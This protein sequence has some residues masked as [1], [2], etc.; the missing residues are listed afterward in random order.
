MNNSQPEKIQ[1]SLHKA[2]EN[3]GTIEQCALLNYPNYINLGDHLIWLGTLF[4]LTDVLQTKINYAASTK[5]FSGVMMEKQIGKAPILLHGGGNLGDLWYGHQK[6]REHIISKYRDQPIIILPQSIYFNNLDKLKRATK[7]FNSHPNL[8]LFVRDNYSYEVAR[9]NF[10]NCQ[11]IKAP[12]MAFQMV[13]MPIFSVNCKSKKSI[14]YLCREDSEL[15][16]D[17]SPTS[18]EIPNLVVED[19]VSYK[20]KWLLGNP[21]SIWIQGMAQ[22]YREGW[23]RSMATPTEWLSRQI[24]QRSHPYNTKFNTFYNPSMHRR[25]L[26]FMHSAIY[27]LKQ[28][29]LIITNRLHGHILCILL[30]IPHIFLPNSYHKNEAFYET[31]TKEISFCRFVKEASQLQ[32]AIQELYSFYSSH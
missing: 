21:D 30:G 25:S 17:F 8:T 24:W 10:C 6:F 18:I 31:W 16:E 3:L 1:Q 29:S 11:V 27:Q 2:L 28:Y 19:W 4:Y 15:N 22:L 5:D 9:K 13:K 20:C 12:D 26:S 32:E 23:Q 7:I 14:L